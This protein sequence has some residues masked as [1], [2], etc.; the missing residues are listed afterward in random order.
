MIEA[1]GHSVDRISQ[2]LEGGSVVA[3]VTVMQKT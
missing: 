2:S 1:E 3:I